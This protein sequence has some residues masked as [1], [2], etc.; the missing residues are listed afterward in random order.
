MKI[1]FVIPA[2]NEEDRIGA[3]L[4]SIGR[5]LAAGHCDAEVIV[6]NNA[7]T[8]RTRE[9]AG[10]VAGVKLVDEPEKGLVRAR[11]AGFLA[12]TGELVAS[13]DA[14]TMLRKGWLDTVLR[15]FQ[16]DQ[17]LVALLRLRAQSGT[18]RVDMSRV[19]VYLV[20]ADGRVTERWGYVGDQAALDDLFS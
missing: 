20:N 7:S 19:N 5:A 9:R 6:V 12:S 13:I 14:D 2:Y 8:D 17:H 15:E 11:R 10:A 4:A 1:S 16:R 18:K 3:C